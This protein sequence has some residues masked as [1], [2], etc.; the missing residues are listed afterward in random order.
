[1]GENHHET[2]SVKVRRST[3]GASVRHPGG[4]SFASSVTRM[5]AIVGFGELSQVSLSKAGQTGY[6]QRYR[7]KKGRSRFMRTIAVRNSPVS[8]LVEAFHIVVPIAIPMLY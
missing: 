4:W 3:G 8:G 1:M 5:T 7:W 6:R 2:G